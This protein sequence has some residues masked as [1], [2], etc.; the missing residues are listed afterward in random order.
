MLGLLA[1]RAVREAPSH[2]VRT[3]GAVLAVLVILQWTI[4]P[5]MVLGALPLEL[6][7]AHNATAALLLLTTV[8]LLRFVWTPHTDLHPGVTRTIDGWTPV[9]VAEGGRLAAP[10]GASGRTAWI[11]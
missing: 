6:A 4:G 8:A 1:W 3:V 11:R 7:T 9:R 5:V 10:A 2:M